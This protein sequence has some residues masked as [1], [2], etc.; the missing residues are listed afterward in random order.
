[1]DREVIW[2]DISQD[3]Q[4][5]RKLLEDLLPWKQKYKVLSFQILEEN[6]IACEVKFKASLDINICDKDGLNEFLSEFREITNTTYNIFKRADNFKGKKHQLTGFRKCIHKVRKRL[7]KNEEISKEKSVGKNTD[8]ESY[9]TF[10]LAN[11]DENHKHSS[12]T[13]EK[14]SLRFKIFYSHNHSIK[15]SEATKFHDVIPSTKQKFMQLFRLG[16]SPSSVYREY[17]ALLRQEHP[18]D[19]NVISAD[20]AVMPDYKWCFNLYAQFK[21]EMFGKINSPEAMAKVHQRIEAFN[22][23]RGGQKFAAIKQLGNG[24]FVI[25]YCDGLCRRVHEKVPGAGDIAF[26]DMTSSLDRQDCKLMRI[27]T[28]SPAGGLPLGFCILSCETEAVITESLKLFK[29]V[30]PDGAFYGRGR[31]TGPKLILTDDAE[32]E[33]SAIRYKIKTGDCSLITF[34]I[35]R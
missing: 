27:M 6:D 10:Q 11:V 20:R 16:G 19:F 35:L 5:K 22:Q 26:M 34:I 7:N 4:S 33:I 30:L 25:A 12:D 31:D 14:Y 2:G 28:T 17:K 24:D 13:C 23:E 9:F 32:A 21:E 29:E 8:C 18:D 15:S 3:N 1:M